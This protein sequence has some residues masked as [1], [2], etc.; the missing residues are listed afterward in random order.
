MKRVYLSVGV[1]AAVFGLSGCVPNE[2]NP[3]YFGQAVTFGVSAAPS[4]AAA[5]A[6]D[7]TVG[8]KQA[9]VAIVPTIVP[10]DVP[11]DPSKRKIVS[12]GEGS[13]SRQDAL[14]V[15]GSFSGDAEVNK[16][17][18]GVFFATGVAAQNLSEGFRCG[19]SGNQLEGCKEE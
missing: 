15:F 18:I 2:G 9:D 19:T 13:D 7:F 6:V 12:F 8:F 3:L 1:G 11:V 5:G 17:K 14:S 10:K 4:P 16:T